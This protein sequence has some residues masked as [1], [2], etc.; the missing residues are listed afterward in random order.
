MNSM[1]Y[2]PWVGLDISPQ[3]E[4]KPCCKYTEVLAKSFNEYDNSP[5]LKNLR[6]EF[7][8]GKR[9]DG[10]SRCWRDEDAGLPSKRTLDN[11]YIF[12]NQSPD[13]HGL[14]V[15]GITFGNTCNLACR[16]CT[17]Y[18]SSKWRE[19]SRKLKPYFPDI[20]IFGHN[21]FYKDKYF[22]Q[23]LYARLK[24]GQVRHVEFAGGEPFYADQTKHQ[25]LILQLEDLGPKDISL[26]Y[27][28]NSTRFPDTVILNS[29]KRFK[30]VDVQLSIDGRWDEFDYN[31]WPASWT[32]V[33]P[34]IDLW[35][36][37]AN[38]EP[39]TQLSIS[40][41]VSIF[42]L[43]NL[44]DFLLWCEH[45]GLPK[46]YLGLLSRPD[47]YSITVLPQEGKKLIEQRFEQYQMPELVPIL[48]AMW[49][50]D[51]SNLLDTT[52]KYIKILDK[53]RKQNFQQVFPETYQLLGEKCQTLYQL[54]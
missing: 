50:K 42:T 35:S 17:S 15:L 11:E 49:A 34:N 54:Y 24:S 16:I 2:H 22:T 13:L 29:W 51:D 46:P 23:E 36:E 38:K 28:T 52:V 14:G 5:A 40:H 18:S 31:R 6:Q 33:L 8:N 53:Q 37:Y 30:K 12:N 44:P 47:Y 10:C 20:R 39:N 3:G 9:P 19:E 43:Y 41:T 26:H 21:T 27:I 1:C 7:L 4:F 25:E 48:D 32:D 45:R